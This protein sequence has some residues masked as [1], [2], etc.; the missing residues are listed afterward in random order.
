MN[1]AKI[2]AVVLILAGAVGL[3]YEQFSY[4]HETTQAKLGPLELKVQEKKT[5]NI[6]IWL[7][8]AA[9]GGG[10]LLLV[11]GGKK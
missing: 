5:V 4:T 2:M 9:I 6:P 7:S 8:L 10:V 11:M 3:V 1:A